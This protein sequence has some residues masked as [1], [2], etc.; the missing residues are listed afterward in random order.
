MAVLGDHPVKTG[1]PGKPCLQLPFLEDLDHAVVG[2]VVLDGGDGDAIFG[3]NGGIRIGFGIGKDVP[4]AQPIVNVVP[5]IHPPVVGLHALHPALVGDADPPDPG[6]RD[7]GHV[8]VERNPG[9]EAVFL[10]QSDEPG[11][12]GGGRAEIVRVEGIDGHRHG[13][14]SQERRLGGGGNRA[15]IDDVD[16]YVGPQVDPRDHHPG[17]RIQE[18]GDGDLD[19]IGRGSVQGQSEKTPVSSH[20]GHP[21]RVQEGDGV[22][23]GALFR[24]G[25]HHRDLVILAQTMKKRL[26]SLGVNSVVIRQ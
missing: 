1:D 5:G 9:G 15:G 17:R 12:E 14:N 13:R 25:S 24:G 10:D 23:D 16:S 26:D 2:Q 20:G 3:E 21:Q 7:A 8:D 6:C 11:D 4:V 22:P 19:A 18:S